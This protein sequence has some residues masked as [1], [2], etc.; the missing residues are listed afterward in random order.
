MGWGG[1]GGGGGGGVGGGGGEIA[2]CQA[3]SSI[4]IGVISTE[5]NL[6][7]L[8][9]DKMERAEAHWLLI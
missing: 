2:H 4:D 7:M 5:H 6:Y 3:I 8:C 9:G 1:V